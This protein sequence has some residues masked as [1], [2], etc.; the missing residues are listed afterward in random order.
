MIAGGCSKER[1]CM[2]REIS[3]SS[4]REDTFRY[5]QSYTEGSEKS[6]TRLWCLTGVEASQ[7]RSERVVCM[8]QKTSRIER[9]YISLFGR[10]T[11][12]YSPTSLGMHPQ[13]ILS[14]GM[15]CRLERLGRI[16]LTV[17][18]KVTSMD[19]RGLETSVCDVDQSRC[20][21]QH[22]QVP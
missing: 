11:A 14:T 16:D 3:P 15:C 9:P 10:C 7:A 20:K 17:A 5:F 21:P 13:L 1:R 4:T 19:A 6:K 2:P 8:F 22:P 12:T 18:N